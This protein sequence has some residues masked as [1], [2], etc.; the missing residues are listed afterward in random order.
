MAGAVTESLRALLASLI[1]Y[2]GLFPPASLSMREAVRNYAAYREGAHAW[3]LGRF[4]VPVSRLAEF[5]SAAEPR[6]AGNHQAPALRLSAL[7]G[8]HLKSD[9]AMIDEFNQCNEGVMIDTIELKA[10]TCKDI[11]LAMRQIPAHLPPY[12]EI[13]IARDPHDLVAALARAKARAKVRTGGLTEEAFPSLPDLL[14]FMHRCAEANVPFKATAGLHH[15]L[16]SVHHFAYEADSPSG[17]MP[18][19]LNVFLTAAFL[20]AQTK[21][22]ALELLQE[23]RVDAFQFD[24]SYGSVGHGVA[25]GGH[26]IDAEQLRRAREQFAMSFGSCSFEEPLSDLRAMGL[27]SSPGGRA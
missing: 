5:Q 20:H 2:A 21:V 4:V 19:F 13:P 11:E 6:L 16:R 12:F 1:D 3:M 27:L 8:T 7:A 9:L 25:W 14:R 26:R 18:G 22:N 24:E 10:E 23:T 17:W 15:P